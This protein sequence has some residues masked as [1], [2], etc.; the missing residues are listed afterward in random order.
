MSMVYRLYSKKGVR[1]LIYELIKAKADE[2]GVSIYRIE[3]DTKISNGTIGKWG[4]LLTR[5]HPLKT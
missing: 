4:R 3:K 1:K 5:N 2:K